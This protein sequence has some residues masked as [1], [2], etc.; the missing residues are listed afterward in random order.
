MSPPQVPLICICQVDAQNLQR[1]IKSKP[2]SC[3][4]TLAC[5]VPAFGLVLI[6]DA[7]VVFVL[8]VFVLIAV[9]SSNQ[10]FFHLIIGY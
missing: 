7:V 10:T 3:C 4:R 6:T 5:V 8:L 9:V 1:F 2:N